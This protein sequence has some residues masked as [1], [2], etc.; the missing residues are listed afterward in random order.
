MKVEKT[1]FNANIFVGRIALQ[2]DF[3]FSSKSKILTLVLHVGIK[4][5]LKPRFY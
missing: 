2:I 3:Q 4:R 1:L 5:C